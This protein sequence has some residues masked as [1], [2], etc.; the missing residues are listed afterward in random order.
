MYWNSRNS[1]S[2]Q[3]IMIKLKMTVFKIG[4]ICYVMWTDD[5]GWSLG[6]NILHVTKQ[7]GRRHHEH[8]RYVEVIIDKITQLSCC[9]RT[10]LL[11]RARVRAFVR[12]C[13]RWRARVC[14]RTQTLHP[15]KSPSD[16][17]CDKYSYNFDQSESRLFLHCRIGYVECIN[18]IVWCLGRIILRWR[19]PAS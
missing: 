1:P 10:C 4:R 6:W 14:V 2:D 11:L 19:P 5:F 15:H 17:A 13:V 12:S 7:G 9:A 16:K 3:A 8:Q 18:G